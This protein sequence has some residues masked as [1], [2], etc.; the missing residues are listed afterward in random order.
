MSAERSVSKKFASSVS[1]TR[2]NVRSAQVNVVLQRMRM[3][4]E[5]NYIDVTT[6]NTTMDRNMMRFID[7]CS[8]SFKVNL[9]SR[10]FNASSFVG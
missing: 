3:R 10:E 2:F 4:S 1:G 9:V 8:R 5:S 6:F 7:S